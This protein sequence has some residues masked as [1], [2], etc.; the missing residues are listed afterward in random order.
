[1]S[2]NL[3][4]KLITRNL[5]DELIAGMQN[6]SGIYIM[7]SFLMQSG[8][9]L[10]A[11][12]LKKALDRGAE[13][14]MLA[15]DYLYITQPEGLRKLLAIDPRLEARLWRSMGTSFHPKAY[16][17][18]YENGE[19][20]LIV[21]SS[22]FSFSALKT[23]YEWNLAMNAQAEPYTFQNAMDQFM[24]NLYHEA[25]LPLTED[26]I[27][28]Y[29]EEYLLN[30]RKNPELQRQVIEMEQAEVEVGEPEVEAAAE[31]EKSDAVIQPRPA[32]EMALDALE[33]TIEEEYDR[34]MV[35]M[36]T[37]LGKTYLAA[38]LARKYQR[39]LFV[40]HR[41]EILHQAARS[42]RHVLPDRTHGLYNGQIKDADADCVFAS[43]YTLGMKKHRERFA[44]DAFDLI[45]I[46]EFHHA[47][48]RSYQSVIEYFRPQFML[49]ITATPDRMDG[50]DVYALCGGNVAY[51]IHFIEAIRREW[52]AP[53]Q[54]Y[55]VHDETDYS[56]IRWLGG[57]YDEEQLLAAQLREEY[58]E[59][60]YEAWT[61]R[62]QTRTLAF[63][64]SIQ[65]TD[66]LAN[67]FRARGVSALS[68]HSRT[69]EMSREEAIRRLDAA[70]LEI[71]FT[72]DLFNEGTDI[73]SV[74]TLLFVRPTDSL[75]VFTQQVGRG[76]RLAEGKSHCVIIDLIGNYRNADVKLSLFVD[77]FGMG[78]EGAKKERLTAIENLPDSCSIQLETAVVNLLEE[79]G[80]KR[81]PLR[82][83]LHRDFLDLK[84]ELGR[85]P[86]YLELHLQGRSISKAYRDEFGSYVGFL[87]WAEMMSEREQQVYE[88][89]EAW[90]RDVEK[91]AMAKSYKMIVLLYML[92]RGAEHWNEPVTAE[93]TAAFFHSYLTEK[94][95]RKRIDFSDKESKRLWDW[96]EQ[97]QT[98]VAKLIADMPMSKW[99]GAKGSQVEFADGE[100]RLAFD[101]AEEDKALLYR[102]TREICEYRLHVHFERRA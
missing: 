56:G 82:E 23:G 79:M 35:V 7:T 96:N 51:R 46:D 8:V 89:Y 52:L 73:P 95:Y 88:R 29:E 87:S 45:V 69:R 64:S 26:S 30:H 77:P 15:G 12:Q 80:R 102:W 70:E 101:V 13:V 39:V 58:A 90:L 14:K 57:H 61:A 40:A 84:S 21:G 100:F 37:G 54:Y 78:D 42:F 48:A 27:A 32:Q 24:E 20:L 71:L 38:F 62:K 44:P 94:E 72:V 3:N 34:A 6:A 43:I 9:N 16:L 81:A 97:T 1:M 17:F 31:E 98:K 86:T 47:A 25:T 19:G 10:L 83:K 63:C 41:E 33:A 68:L 76:L 55:G 28:L 74:D 59:R 60:V 85:I 36:A 2:T 22:N 92:E 91:T 50:Q 67:Y 49:G 5:A 75:T 66:Y 11:P 99:A 4:V 65:Q 53:F 18:D 93:E